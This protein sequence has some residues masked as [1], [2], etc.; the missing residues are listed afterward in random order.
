ME[1]FHPAE[2]FQKH[3][4]GSVRGVRRIIHNAIDKPVDRL[5]KLADQP[6]V[7]VLRTRLQFGDD[8]GFFSPGPDS[9]SKIAQCSSSRHGGVAPNYRVTRAPA[10]GIFTFIET[11]P[12]DLIPPNYLNSAGARGV[13]GVTPVFATVISSAAKYLEGRPLLP[14]PALVSSLSF[15]PASS[16]GQCHPQQSSAGAEVAPPTAFSLAPAGASTRLPCWRSVSA[17][18]RPVFDAHS[19]TRSSHYLDSDSHLWIQTRP[20]F[21][22]PNGSSRRARPDCDRV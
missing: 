22:P 14:A 16:E 20:P 3:V 18:P 8:G 15:L 6:R 13:P 9:A 10:A 5:M 21:P 2:D 4:L 17:L 12:G 11:L 7:C 19:P 1:M